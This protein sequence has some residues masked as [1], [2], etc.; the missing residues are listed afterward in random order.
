M[1][2]RPNIPLPS[3]FIG[4]TR[5][6]AGVVRPW[7]CVVV[8]S[9][10]ARSEVERGESEKLSRVASERDEEQKS[11]LERQEAEYK[12]KMRQANEAYEKQRA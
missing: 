6:R 5:K 12:E 8:A 9:N 1:K 7:T 3:L 4:Q 10:E 11:L 2:N